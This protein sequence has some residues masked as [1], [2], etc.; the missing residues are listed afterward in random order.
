LK[1]LCS[2]R[3][4]AACYMVAKTAGTGDT[5][6]GCHHNFSL[7][8][9]AENSFWD[10]DARGL[11]QVA[12]H[13]AAG[14]LETMPALTL[15]YHPWVNSYRRTDHEMFTPEIASWGE[16]NHFAGLRVVYGAVPERMTRFENRVPGADVN[17]YLS[18]AAMLIGC[19]RGIRDL[20]EPPPYA[21]GPTADESCMPLPRTL[22]EAVELFGKSQIVAEALGTAFVEHLNYIKLEE[23]KDYTAA[24]PSAAQAAAKGPITDWEI[25]RYFKHA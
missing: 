4:L 6:C 19:L 23:W 9:G 5:Y 21:K 14:I 16:D 1:Q 15:L 3:G 12:R 25:A 20:K 7:A 22:P 13:A 17:P 8:R 2:E 10:K 24:V 11:S 18:I